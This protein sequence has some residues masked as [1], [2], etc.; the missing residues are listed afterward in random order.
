[1]NARENPRSNHRKAVFRIHDILVRIRIR[2]SMPLALTDGSGS[3]FIFGSCS[4]VTDL[5]DANKKLIKKFL[6]FLKVH[7]HN[8]LK[9]KSQKEVTK[10]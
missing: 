9:I 2:R 10:R 3:G 5:Q 1:M 4:F 6:H 8:F 7:L